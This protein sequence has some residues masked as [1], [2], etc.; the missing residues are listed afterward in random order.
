MIKIGEQTGG[1]RSFLE[2]AE[3]CVF[4]ITRANANEPP[5]HRHTSVALVADLLYAHMTGLHAE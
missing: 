5:T 4:L 2:A 1:V 3:F